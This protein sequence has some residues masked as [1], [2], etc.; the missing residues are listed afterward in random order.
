MVQKRSAGL[1]VFRRVG[2]EPEVLLV[3]PGGPFWTN[4]DEWGIPKGEYHDLENPLEAA[5]REFEEEIGQPPPTDNVIVLGDIQLKSGK[6]ITAWAVEGNLD[7]SIVH[8][9][10]LAM[11]WPPHSGT[12]IEIPEVDKAH[13]FLISEAR[14]KMHNR[15]ETFI[16]RLSSY[17]GV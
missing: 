13:W 2:A 5:F 17:L 14:A 10:L 16:L 1:L 4:R 8:S 6:I 12:M 11:E 3:H 7:V 15:Q 9:N